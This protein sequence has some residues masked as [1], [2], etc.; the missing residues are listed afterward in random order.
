M[1]RKTWMNILLSA[2]ISISLSAC[3]NDTGKKEEVG[4]T[5]SDMIAGFF[6]LNGTDF[7]TNGKKTVEGA[8]PTSDQNGKASAAYAFDGEKNA[9]E[10]PH[11]SEFNIQDKITLSSWVYT[12]SKRSAIILR[13]GA[14]VNGDSRCPYELATSATGDVIFSLN[15]P[16]NGN[17][18]WIQLRKSGYAKGEWFHVAGTYDGAEMKLYIDGDLENTKSATGKM[19]TNSSPLLIGTRLKIASSTWNGKIAD[20]RIYN[21]ALSSNEIAELAGK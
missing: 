20:V 3:S 21:R 13:K 5:G 14:E 7:V 18:T 9:I 1:Q 17:M 10:I 8:T 6:Y 16:V 4:G 15:L 2:A 12:E 19:N 11:R